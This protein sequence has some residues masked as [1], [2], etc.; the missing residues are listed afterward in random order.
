MKTFY[1]RN[2]PH[3]QP[4]GAC[5]FVTFRLYNSVPKIAIDA[6][7]E[8]YTQ[9]VTQ[10]FFI[11][12]AHKRNLEIFNLRKKYL[13]ELDGILDKIE[14]GPHYLKDLSIIQI[15]DKEIKRYDGTLYNLIAYCI[16][17]NHVHL[18]IDT[19]VQLENLKED[20]ELM[21]SYQPLDKILKQIKGSTSRYINLFLHRSGQFWERES[22]DIYIRNEK[23]LNN[24]ISYTLNNP[25]KAGIVENWEDF[26]GNYFVE[27]SNGSPNSFG[28]V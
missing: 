17:S 22:F 7:S 12:E 20:T 23:M 24:V 14:T 6:L 25:M 15:I 1:R 8:K 4:V 28:E 26:R 19:A 10:A 3:I 21:Q 11:E 13:I 16:M 9:R 18:V 27:T 5:F 2:L